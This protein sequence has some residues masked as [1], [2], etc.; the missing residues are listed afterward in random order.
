MAKA[1]GSY[2][3]QLGVLSVPTTLHTVAQPAASKTGRNRLHAECGHKLNQVYVCKEHGDPPAILDKE[4]I[5]MGYE[6]VKGKYVL[7]TDEDLANMPMPDKQVVQISSFAPAAEIDAAQF[8]GAYYLEAEKGGGKGFTA[9]ARAMEEG[10]LVA[11]ATICV[12][13]KEQLCALRVAQSR[14]YL[15]PLFYQSEM[16]VEGPGQWPAEV[17]AAELA[18]TKTLVDMHRQP[19]DLEAHPDKFTNAFQELVAWKLA[20]PGATPTPTQQKAAAPTT[21]LL[22][23]LKASIEATRPTVK[24]NPPDARVKP[25]KPAAKRAKVR[26]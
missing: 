12:R 26:A 6:Y 14:L 8:E 10:G 2:V 15:H 18:M 4:Q 22:S 13:S 7:I 25:A 17:T 21:D 11:I 16:N 23:A 1:I 20:N 19:F 3:L 5:V 9:I 24:L